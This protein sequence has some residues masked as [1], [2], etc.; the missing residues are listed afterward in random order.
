MDNLQEN[1][2]YQLAEI[3]YKNGDYLKAEQL[4]KQCLVGSVNQYHTE[5]CANKLGILYNNPGLG[6]IYIRKAIENYLIA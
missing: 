1:Y 4:L 3:Y 5:I 6:Q 2:I